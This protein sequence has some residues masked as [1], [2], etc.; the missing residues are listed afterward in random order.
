M[1][2]KNNFSIKLDLT[3]LSQVVVT[4]IKGKAGNSVPVVIIPIEPNGIFVGK[5]G[6][7]LNLAAFV[8]NNPQYGQSHIVK[9][10]LPKEESDRL[11]E[12][13]KKAL[14]ILGNMGVLEKHEAQPVPVT[15]VTEIGDDVK[16]DLPF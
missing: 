5:K 8:V 9:R 13:E 11:T 7:Y 6:S 12:E 14:P 3:K 10:S 1:P 2:E 15:G 16:D 4:N